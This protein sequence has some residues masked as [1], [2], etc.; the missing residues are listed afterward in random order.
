MDNNKRFQALERM[1]TMVMFGSL[2][3]FVLYLVFAG[4]G[5][6]WMKYLTAAAVFGLSGFL[7]YVLISAREATKQRSLWLTFA[8]GGMILC[9]LVSLL[10]RFP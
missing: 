3:C 6:G 2:A 8:A 4:L 10:V 9:V 1:L 5:I 7:L